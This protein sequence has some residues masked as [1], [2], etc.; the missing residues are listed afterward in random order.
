MLNNKKR[1]VARALA[2]ALAFSTVFGISAPTDV[3]AATKTVTVSTQKDLNAALKDN[4]IK[5]II[6]KSPSKKSFTIK[7][8]S[9]K[10][11]TLIVN[12]AK[13]NVTNAGKF[14]SITIKDASKYTEA[15]KN[16]A[17][18][19]TDDKLSLVI[20]SNA[21]VRSLELAKSGAKDSLVVD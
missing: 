15:A 13:L 11:K 20:E 14:Q 4:K 12:G 17:V 10:K 8:G 9:Y 6:I 3:Y 19:V 2:A 16:N 7:Q 18:K 5:K 1:I 21:V